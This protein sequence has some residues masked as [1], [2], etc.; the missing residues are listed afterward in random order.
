MERSLSSRRWWGTA[1]C[2]V[3]WPEVLRWNWEGCYWC[4]LLSKWAVMCPVQEALWPGGRVSCLP[5]WRNLAELLSSCATDNLLLRMNESCWAEWALF[6]PVACRPACSAISWL[7]ELVGVACWM[8]SRLAWSW[9]AVFFVRGSRQRRREWESRLLWW[10]SYCWL[11]WC[12]GWCTDRGRRA[13]RWPG[14]NRRRWND[15]WVSPQHIYA[16][17]CIFILLT[18]QSHCG[19]SIFKHS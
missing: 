2:A 8:Q 12:V 11:G 17:P 1:G 4:C 9:W 15:M 16:V 5:A 13:V 3:N 18:W 7:A 10:L 19:L 6:I 14:L